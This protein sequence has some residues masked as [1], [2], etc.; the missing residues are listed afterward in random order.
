MCM[1]THA[2]LPLLLDPPV[3]SIDLFVYPCANKLPCMVIASQF[4]L[5]F[6]MAK[7]SQLSLPGSL[8]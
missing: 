8:V 2:H 4:A 1:C 7:S 3:F 6:V 5:V